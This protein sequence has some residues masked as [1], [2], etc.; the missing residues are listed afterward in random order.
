MARARKALHQFSGEL[1][2]P[3]LVEEQGPGM[4]SAMFLE[5]EIAEKRGAKLGLL[6]AHYDIQPD[7]KDRWRRLSERLAADFVP[8]MIAVDLPPKKSFLTRQGKKWT[9]Q[10]YEDFVG[11]IDEIREKS[12]R[13]RIEWAIDQLVR[14]QP[15]QWRK[16]KKESLKTR[17]HE[18]KTA[19]AES[20]KRK[21]SASAWLS[22]NPK[23][24]DWRKSKPTGLPFASATSSSGLTPTLQVEN[25]R[26]R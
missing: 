24:R 10:Q 14:K 22:G 6:L 25:T 13:K 11:A 19:V 8:G 17:Y 5:R 16:Y 7:D 23:R 26:M 2:A 12:K 21:A 15:E 20:A 9:L 4:L 1:A 18:G 3:I